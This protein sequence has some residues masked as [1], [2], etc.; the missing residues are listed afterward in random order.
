VPTRPDHPVREPLRLQHF[1]F[2]AIVLFYL[3]LSLLV[4]NQIEE[5]AFIYFRLV[6][7]IA[8]GG[9]VVFNQGG[10]RVEAGSSMLW[11]LLL[12]LLR[13]VPLQI[14]IT[15][16]LVGLVCGCVG[17]WL[18]YRLCRLHIRD[19]VLRLVP[20]LLTAANT[21]FLMWSQRGLETPLFTVLL[22]WLVLCCSAPRAFR[23]WPVP[24]VLLLP[25]RPE[26]LFFLLALLPAFVFHRH[27]WRRIRRSALVVAAAAL[28]LLTCRFLY[29]HDLVPQPF[30]LKLRAGGAPGLS[31]IHS[32]LLS[33]H[34]YVFAIPLLLVVWRPRFW[35][36]P[37]IV[38][39]GFVL[40][41]AAWSAIPKDHMPYVRHLVPALPLLYVLLVG[42]V[43]T[44]ASGS[45]RIRSAAAFAYAM[46]VLAVTLLFSESAGPGIGRRNPLRTFL[47]A[48]AANPARHVRETAIKIVSPSSFGHLDEALGQRET[49]GTNYQSLVGEFL[50]ANYP[51][52]SLVVYDQMG[53]TPY[54]GGAQMRFVDS[55]GL[56]DRTIARIYVERSA[57]TNALRVYNAVISRAVELAFGEHRD[58]ITDAKALDYLFG[59]DPDLVLINSFLVGFDPKGIPAQLM[60]D[61][62]LGRDYELRYTLGRVVRLYERK[63]RF[64]RRRPITAVGLDVVQ[65]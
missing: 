62:R 48:F 22:L 12:V 53:Q 58:A 38:L 37:R 61:P 11:L 51:A 20:P 59:I 18:V 44:L 57:S 14:V 46:V 32:Y 10:P 24:A 21:P 4:F 43:D 39:V 33:S 54:Y 31:Q 25:A 55:L 3:G 13:K 8:Q 27:E 36:Q 9:G 23:W 56:T 26:G 34:L 1:A 41:T 15:A 30:Y 64:G 45:S 28:G 47:A 5:D 19:P 49:L 17:L 50:H 60:R 65:D 7:N 52:H 35:T 40:T 42:A 16:K 2:G 63:G 29:F 6:D